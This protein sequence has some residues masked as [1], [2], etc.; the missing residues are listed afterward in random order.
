MNFKAS[1]TLQGLIGMGCGV[2][3]L[4][5]PEL[6]LDFLTMDY[7]PIA[8][9]LFRIL[10]LFVIILCGVLFALRPVESIP[11]QRKVLLANMIGDFCIAGLLLWATMEELLTNTGGWVFTL[12]MLGNALSYLPAYFGLKR[13]GQV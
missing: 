6:V 3:F 7:S 12:F 11:I 8:V 1:M 5:V 2:V 4:L 9:L 13:K 10:S